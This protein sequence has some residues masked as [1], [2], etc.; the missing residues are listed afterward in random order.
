MPNIAVVLK[1]EIARLARKEL[2]AEVEPL[3]KAITALKQDATASKKRIKEL[4]T[5]LRQVK[6]LTQKGAVVGSSDIDE[7]TV[8]GA[9][10]SAKGLASNRRRLGLSAEDFALLAGAT[11]QSIY[12]WERGSATPR[13]DSIAAI[14]GLRGIG[15]REVAQR[16]GALKAEAARAPVGTSSKK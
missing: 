4:E 8:R 7:G 16:L 5:E 6:K 14:A 10:F 2:R 12:A 1:E 13:S 9:R 15:K 11:A 3:R